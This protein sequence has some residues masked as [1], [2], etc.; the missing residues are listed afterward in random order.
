MNVVLQLSIALIVAV[1]FYKAISKNDK[2]FE[3]LRISLIGV[4][5]GFLGAIFEFSHVSPFLSMIDFVMFPVGFVFVVVGMGKHS[6]IMFSSNHMESL[7]MSA[8][9]DCQDY[10]SKYAVCPKC[11]GASIRLDVTPAQ[12]P[13]CKAHYN[14]GGA[15]AT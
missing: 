2:R 4:M 10:D 7:D 13:L 1:I 6:K 11:E 8:D 3:G 14:E 15:R 12:C 9:Y 5:I